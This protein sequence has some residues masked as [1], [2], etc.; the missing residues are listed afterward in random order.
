MSD[1][2]RKLGQYETRYQSALNAMTS[3]LRCLSVDEI[4]TAIES[5]NHELVMG[6]R[7]LERVNGHERKAG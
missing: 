6:K 4:E 2:W 3:A 5:L 7:F 1:P